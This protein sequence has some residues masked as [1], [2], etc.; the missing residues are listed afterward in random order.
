MTDTN[1]ATPAVSEAW[2]D[3]SSAA[4]YMAQLCKH[5]AHRIPVT[6]NERDGQMVF[7][8]GTCNATAEETGLRL[9]ASAPDEEDLHEVERV[10]ITHLQRFAFRDLTEEAAAAIPWVGAAG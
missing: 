5:F 6:L 9:R 7:S 3:T 10:V 1:N 2:W 8:F 4:R